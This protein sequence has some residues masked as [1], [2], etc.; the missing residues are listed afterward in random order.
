[1]ESLEG[2]LTSSLLT[3]NFNTSNFRSKKLEVRSKKSVYEFHLF[4]G[5]RYIW[6]ISIP[7]DNHTWYFWEYKL[8]KK[9]LKKA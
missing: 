3:S 7:N 9:I 6:K 4:L 2:L 5:T 1:M 8:F